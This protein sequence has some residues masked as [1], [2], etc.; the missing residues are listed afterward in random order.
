MNYFVTYDIFSIPE[1]DVLCSAFGSRLMLFLCAHL[2]WISLTQ[3]SRPFSLH[4]PRLAGV[5]LCVVRCRSAA[6]SGI[7]V[8]LSGV[9]EGLSVLWFEGIQGL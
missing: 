8:L 3:F 6:V 7:D 2:S 1:L 5:H 9:W 4:R